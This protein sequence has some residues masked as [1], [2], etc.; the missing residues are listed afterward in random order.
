MG[1]SCIA[2]QGRGIPKKLIVCIIFPWK[3]IFHCTLSRGFIVPYTPNGNYWMFCVLGN[4]L[5]RE[6]NIEWV[7]FQYTTFW[8][9]IGSDAYYCW[10]YDTTTYIQSLKY[11]IVVLVDKISI[12]QQLNSVIH[13]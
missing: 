7:N 1:T 4:T 5:V 13:L 9:D 12:E 10:L 6:G 8:N 3:A 2:L 11:K